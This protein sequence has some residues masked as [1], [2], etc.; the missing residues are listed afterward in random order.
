MNTGGTLNDS[1]CV[2]QQPNAIEST[3]MNRNKIKQFLLYALCL[4]L[5]PVGSEAA[6]SEI[7]NPRVPPAQI[8]EARSLKNPFPPTKENMKKAKCF[9]TVR[10]FV[11]PAT[12]PMVK[13]WGKFQGL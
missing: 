10:H 2:S 9:F 8:E 4:G 12:D 1:P 6:D 7:L 3:D 13:G 5:W 11:L